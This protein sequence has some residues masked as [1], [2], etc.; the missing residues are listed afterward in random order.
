MATRTT[1]V[2]RQESNRI[3]DAIGAS[4]N[5]RL[6]VCGL[7]LSA[8]FGVSCALLLVTSS[9]DSGTDCGEQ[10]DWGVHV[11][12]SKRM[13]LCTG[14]RC[15]KTQCGHVSVNNDSCQGV[16]RPYADRC[17]CC[18]ACV[19]QLGAVPR[20]ALAQHLLPLREVAGD[21][22]RPPVLRVLCP[23]QLR[24][25]RRGAPGPGGAARS[26]PRQPAPK[27]P[28]GVR[29]RLRL[30][31]HRHGSLSPGKAF[32]LRRGPPGLVARQGNHTF[33]SRLTRLRIPLS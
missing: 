32:V 28:G 17:R 13:D 14:K 30:P 15:Q 24:V 18:E 5:T 10:P 11:E 20:T 12:P 16:V 1:W 26:V 27:A 2:P 21:V 4:K 25:Q 29:T 6:L 33:R 31:G 8:V 9:Q 22:G 23:G 7:S 3:E 19:L